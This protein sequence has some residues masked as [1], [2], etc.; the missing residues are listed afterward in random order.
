MSVF[1]G[2]V[3]ARARGLTGHLLGRRRLESLAQVPDLVVLARD[4]GALGYP[5]DGV[6]GDARPA[7]LD[8]AARRAVAGRLRTLAR[9]CGPRADALAVVFE[10]EDRRSVRG[11]LRGA[12]EGPPESVRLAGLVPTP[13]LPERAL[14]ELARQP[15]AGAVAGLLAAW[16]NPYGHALLPEAAS[17]TPDLFALE[18]RCNQ[19][20]AERALR[21]ARRGPLVAYVRESVDLENAFAAL[22]LAESARDVSPER[23]FLA[24]GAALDIGRFLGAIA[25]GNLTGAA[26]HLGGAFGRSPLAQVFRRLDRESNLESQVLGYRI[27][28]LH[29]AALLDPLGPAP[30]L[31]YVLRLRAEL[32]DLGSIIWGIFLGVP[33]AILA[34]DL[35]TAA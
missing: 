10:D 16:G 15:S 22:A 13:S 19:A 33:R 23:V 28:F 1:W 14:R 20:F 9:W 32:I 8:L 31:A 2:D 34:R 12:V 6:G 7:V 29:R 27:G 3:N 35:V 17:P 25:L 21:G 11:L 4:L 26:Q 18:V 5:Q 30:F 24:G